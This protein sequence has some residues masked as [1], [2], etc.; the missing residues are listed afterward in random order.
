M[1]YQFCFIT[2][3]M[4]NGNI[5]CLL[6]EFVFLSGRGFEQKYYDELNGSI[7]KVEFS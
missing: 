6:R 4:H 2:I 5:K 1:I 7:N 3:F